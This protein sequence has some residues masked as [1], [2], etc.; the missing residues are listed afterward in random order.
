VR[1]SDEDIQLARRLNDLA[2][3]TAAK[4]ATAPLA[5]Q[6]GAGLPARL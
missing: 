6:P 4:L 2:K 3:S 5:A 1:R